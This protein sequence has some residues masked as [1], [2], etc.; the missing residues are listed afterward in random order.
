MPR[1]SVDRTQYYYNYYARTKDLRRYLY[2]QKKIQTQREEAL[3]KPYGG[4]REYYRN[5]LIEMGVLQIIPRD[6]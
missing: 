6:E 5:R 1:Y 4:E 3:Y 2:Y